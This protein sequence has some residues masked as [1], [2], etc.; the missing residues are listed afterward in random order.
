MKNKDERKFL[1][2]QKRDPM[3][4][5]TMSLCGRPLWISRLV[6]VWTI[7]LAP[8][9]AQSS[10]KIAPEVWDLAKQGGMVRVFIELPSQPQSEIFRRVQEDQNR[11]IDAARA[12]SQYLA[13]PPI[14]HNP[15]LRQARQDLDALTVELREEAG[16]Q[17]EAEIGP[18][19]DYMEAKL[20]GLGARNVLHYRAINML[21]A[22]IPAASL[23]VLEQMRE[24]ARISL[25]GTSSG[26]GT[27]NVEAINAELFWQNGQ[28]QGDGQSVAIVD[29]AI[30]TNITH[31]NGYLFAAPRKHLYYLDANRCRPDLDPHGTEVASV[32]TGLGLEAAHQ[33]IVQGI[34]SGAGKEGGSIQSLEVMCYTK[35][36]QGGKPSQEESNNADVVDALSSAIAGRRFQQAGVALPALPALNTRIFN[37][38]IG[39][40][41]AE[42][43]PI[44]AKLLDALVPL[45]PEISLAVAAGNLGD[46]GDK[47]I[48]DTGVAY[49]VITVGGMDTKDTDTREDDVIYKRS[50]PD[51]TGS[52]SIGPTID[53]RKKPD[54]VAPGTYVPIAKPDN[55]Y[56]SATGTSLAAPEVTGAVALLA[57]TGVTNGLAAKAM[58]INSAHHDYKDANDFLGWRKDT[59]WGYLDLEPLLKQVEL[60]K[61]NG[62]SPCVAANELAPRPS[63][64]F[65]GMAASQ[66]QQGDIWQYTGNAPANATLKAT[67]TWFRHPKL[68]TLQNVDLFLYKKINGAWSRIGSSESR[69][70]N[71]EQ[72]SDKTSAAAEYLVKVK[73]VQHFDATEPSEPFALATS[74]AFQHFAGPEVSVNCIAPAPAHPLQSV[75]VQCTASNQGQLALP[76]ATATA[77]PGTVANGNLGSIDGGGVVS[78]AVSAIAPA[79]VGSAFPVVVTV[80]GTLAEETYQGST[81]FTI[82][83]VGGGECELTILQ[84]PGGFFIPHSGQ[85][86]TFQLNTSSPDCQ[87]TL[88][89]GPLYNFSVVVN[90]W[91]T[92]S[93]TS[94]TGST[95]VS[96]SVLPNLYLQARDGGTLVG[97]VFGKPA[98]DFGSVEADFMV[99]IGDIVA[100]GNGP[101]Y[102]C[103]PY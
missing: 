75:M 45:Q 78:F 40:K 43:Y 9:S 86:G 73:S 54:L 50:R 52:S 47:S 102:A 61:K 70:D 94:G 67:L 33:I 13:D 39:A 18:Q 62:Q 10:A 22:E 4:I 31:F 63:G 87:W 12:R 26:F 15:Q 36:A 51:Q 85:S 37:L 93:P 32:V 82:S 17:I 71:V 99:C 46:D 49:N 91:I 83:A 100:S 69:V 5:H 97:A 65:M 42:D 92:V 88:G 95:V 25:V 6:L 44:L 59:G 27:T 55:H 21:A 14:P 7:A 76:N 8:L 28:N 79:Q 89:V 29:S 80:S 56:D 81:S 1:T 98:S 53:G 48:C 38:S 101:G 57:G 23:P 103:Y 60:G 90:P 34:A 72:V 66:G 84:P 58:L 16:R 96:Y 11:R 64:C 41:A 20:L 3:R 68:A 35:A 24:I 30:Q 19:Q 2:F 74:H 77:N